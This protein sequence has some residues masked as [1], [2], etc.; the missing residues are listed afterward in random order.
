MLILSS[1][2]PKQNMV[3]M[4][5]NNFEQEISQARYQGLHIQEGDVLEVIVSAFDELAVKPFNKTTMNQSNSESSGSQNNRL[6]NN[7]YIVSSEGSISFPVLGEVYC[8]GMSQ[9][10]LKKDLEKRL[11]LYLSDPLVT[12]RLTNFNISVLGD[13]KSPGQKTSPTEKL[14]IFR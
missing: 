5:N 12:I 9:Q 6:G 7:E 8:K 1:C 13:V 10:Q 11:K 3:Y 14:N 4:G 2:T